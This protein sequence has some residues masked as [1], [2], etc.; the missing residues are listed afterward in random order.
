MRARARQEDGGNRDKPRRSARD[1]NVST[2]DVERAS[3][4]TCDGKRTSVNKAPSGG[5][6]S[7]STA[8]VAMVISDASQPCMGT[9]ST[10]LGG[11]TGP[12]CAWWPLFDALIV[13]PFAAS[14]AIDFSGVPVFPPLSRSTLLMNTR[15]P[16]PSR[17]RKTKPRPT[18]PTWAREEGVG[19][20]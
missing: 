10:T 8:T 5:F 7:R 1:E 18:P 15:Q 14:R 3:S 12:A 6:E 2:S 4:W 20:A 11:Q 9:I 13:I 17:L 16:I 19:A